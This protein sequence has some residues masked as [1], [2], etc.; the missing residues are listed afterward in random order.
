MM[1]WFAVVRRWWWRRISAD[2][3][4][5]MWEVRSSRVSMVPLWGPCAVLATMERRFRKVRF[6]AR[7][8]RE[9][10]L[11]EV[12]V[13]KLFT[14]YFVVLVSADLPIEVVSSALSF[15]SDCLDKALEAI[16]FL[17]S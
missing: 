6:L 1:R 3:K 2:W 16:A 7:G 11:L 12:W 17:D 14:T 4:R 9:V 8:F 15:L 10:W 13:V 5:K